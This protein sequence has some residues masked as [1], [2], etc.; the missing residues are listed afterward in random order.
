MRG[1]ISIQVWY[2][3]MRIR[4]NGLHVSGTIAEE[5][6]GF[7]AQVEPELDYSITIPSL[8][9]TSSHVVKGLFIFYINPL[10]NRRF[11]G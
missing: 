4:R 6:L 7:R 11:K 3:V 5:L 9:P 2:K 1:G 10:S 8:F